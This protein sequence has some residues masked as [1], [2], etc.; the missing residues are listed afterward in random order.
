MRQMRPRHCDP[1]SKT[2]PKGKSCIPAIIRVADVRISSLC[3]A[4]FADFS[5]SYTSRHGSEDF[6]DRPAVVKNLYRSNQCKMGVALVATHTHFPFFK[7]QVST[8]RSRRV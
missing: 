8:K 3:T 4:R 5:P 1:S 7:T 6:R 2:R